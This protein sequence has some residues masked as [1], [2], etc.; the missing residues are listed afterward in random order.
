MAV[1]TSTTT[2]NSVAA[3]SIPSCHVLLGPTASAPQ[4]H[5]QGQASRDF[6]P[7]AVY[8]LRVS[9]LPRLN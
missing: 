4:A 6:I 2:A 1:W 3:K 5:S 7:L 8:F 9:F